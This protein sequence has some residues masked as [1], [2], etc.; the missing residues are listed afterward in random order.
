MSLII[1]TYNQWGQ[2]W[3]GKRLGSWGLTV[4]RYGCYATSIAALIKNYAIADDPGELVDK[5]NAIVG[6][7]PGGLVKYDS[8]MRAYPQLYFNERV[9]TTNDPSN[10]VQKMDIKVAINRIQHLMKMGFPSILCVDNVLN[11][12]I[13]DHAVVCVEAPYDLSKWKIMNPD[14]GKIENF[15]ER[16]GDVEKFLY[17]FVSIVGPP[18]ESEMGGFGTA[19]WKISQAKKGISPNQYLS[20][21]LDNL[22]HG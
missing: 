17:G 7:D 12:G 19:A 4:G 6:F 20:E 14:G 9:Y 8:V 5:L 22:L 15:K 10:N 18:V 2:P 16:Y 13:P 11:D 3:S 21:A 1:G